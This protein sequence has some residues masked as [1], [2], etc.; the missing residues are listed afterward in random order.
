MDYSCMM[1]ER[2]F[3]DT[4][5][6]FEKLDKSGNSERFYADYFSLIASKPAVYFPD[7]KHQMATLLSM[8]LADNLLAFYRSPEQSAQDPPNPLTKPEIDALEY[9]SGYVVFKMLKKMRNSKLFK[10]E[11]SQRVISFLESLLV[12]GS[13]NRDIRQWKFLETITFT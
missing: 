7:L 3:Y 9:L 1:N 2:L 12:S 6:V 10:S 11:H 13:E 5:K 8:R 4:R